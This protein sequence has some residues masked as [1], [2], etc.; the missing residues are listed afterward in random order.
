MVESMTGEVPGTV[1]YITAYCIISTVICFW[2]VVA[3]DYQWFFVP[4]I[5]V[6]SLIREFSKY[7]FHNSWNCI[8]NLDIF[9]QYVKWT[10][11]DSL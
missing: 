8:G 2:L 3:K 4:R 6:V 9:L 11:I 5:G 1:L 7:L 10:K